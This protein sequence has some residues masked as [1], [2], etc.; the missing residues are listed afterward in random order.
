MGD[1]TFELPPAASAEQGLV[2]SQKAERTEVW[3]HFRGNHNTDIGVFLETLI[4]DPPPAYYCQLLEP[5]FKFV[6]SGFS[7]NLLEFT[8]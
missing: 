6:G 3:E 5:F 1:W 4:I 8:L 7:G 2:K